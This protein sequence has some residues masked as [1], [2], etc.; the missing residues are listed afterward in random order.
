MD[1]FLKD[2]KLSKAGGHYW[3]EESADISTL[4]WVNGEPCYTTKKEK[5][6]EIHA[7]DSTWGLI[8]TAYFE[9]KLTEETWA[10]FREEL[11][12]GA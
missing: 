8:I 3:A 11:E 7:I 12:K 9:G 1:F 2:F 4:R 5:H 6:S 10:K